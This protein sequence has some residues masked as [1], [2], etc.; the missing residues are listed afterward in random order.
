M[1]PLD[2]CYC[3]AFL[4]LLVNKPAAVVGYSLKWQQVAHVKGTT[5]PAA[6]AAAKMAQRQQT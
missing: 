1:G 2:S 4:Y 6:P 5:P 3:P